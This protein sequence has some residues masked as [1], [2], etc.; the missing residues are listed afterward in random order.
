MHLA[1]YG[2]CR[3]SCSELRIVQCMDVLLCKGKRAKDDSFSIRLTLA[4]PL[5]L[6]VANTWC[7]NVAVEPGLNLS[8]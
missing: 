8:L 2:I 4:D 1:S 3:G 5:I 6:H 7:P